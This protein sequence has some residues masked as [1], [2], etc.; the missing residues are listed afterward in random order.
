MENLKMLKS[1]KELE[2]LDN[3]GD[4]FNEDMFDEQNK[5]KTITLLV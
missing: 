5:E 4:E 2:F 1:V 3:D